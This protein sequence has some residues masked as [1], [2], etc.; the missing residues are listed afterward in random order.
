MFYLHVIHLDIRLIVLT[1]NLSK[2]I[3]DNNLQL[4][5][6]GLASFTIPRSLL[7]AAQNGGQLQCMQ[8][9]YEPFALI[10]FI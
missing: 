1:V 8:L 3:M 6:D 5:H 4:A 2:P 10:F 7:V 9:C